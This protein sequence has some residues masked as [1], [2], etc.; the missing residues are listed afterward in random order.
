[1]VRPTIG[2]PSRFSMPATTEL[3]TPPD[4]ATAM[5]RWF[6]EAKSISGM[7]LQAFL[8][9]RA[10][11]LLDG[12][13][14]RIGQRIY[15]FFGVIS[16]QRKAHALPRLPLGTAHREEHMRRLNGTARARGAA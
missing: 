16:S 15:L 14:H 2:R 8:S 12:R 9:I 13:D 11:K 10:T 7:L 4:I 5:G 1:M 3:S 6:P